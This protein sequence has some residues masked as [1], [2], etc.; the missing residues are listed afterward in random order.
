MKNVRLLSLMLVLMLVMS[1]VVTGFAAEATYTEAEILAGA[2]KD[3]GYDFTKMTADEISACVSANTRL[4]VG[5]DDGAKLSINH[6]SNFSGEIQLNGL[7]YSRTDTKAVKV[8]F[9]APDAGTTID[10]ALFSD[11]TRLRL[12][13]YNY[14]GNVVLSCSKNFFSNYVVV[15]GTTYSVIAKKVADDTISVYVKSDADTGYTEILSNR[16]VWINDTTNNWA[17]VSKLSV[18]GNDANDYAIFK[19]VYLYGD[20]YAEAD[21]LANTAKGGSL[22]FTQMT[23]SEI[24]AFGTGGTN[25]TTTKEN[26]MKLE[27]S[28]SSKGYAVVNLGL[29]YSSTANKAVKVT[30]VAPQSGTTIETDFRDAGERYRIYT[31]AAG[32]IGYGST[33]LSGSYV[34]T[35]GETYTVIGKKDSEGK[36]SLY[37]KSAS[38]INYKK[39]ISGV[40]PVTG[41]FSSLFQI[42]TVGAPGASTIFKEVT[43]YVEGGSRADILGT[44]TA[45][46]HDYDFDET[47]DGVKSY[48][49]TSADGFSFEKYGQSTAKFNSACYIPDGGAAVIRFKINNSK[50]EPYI[51]TANN[52][53]GVILI[54]ANGTVKLRTVSN[55]HSYDAGTIKQNTWYTMILK[56]NGTGFDFYMSESDT[57]NFALRQRTGE[58]QEATGT[59]SSLTGSAG[60]CVD[61]F[62]IYGPG[63]EIPSDEGMKLLHDADFAQN[64]DFLTCERVTATNASISNDALALKS[65]GTNEGSYKYADAGIP[66]GGY[67]EVSAK[68]MNF[69]A[70]FDQDDFN[71]SLICNAVG[72]D[73]LADAVVQVSPEA[74]GGGWQK[75][76]NVSHT[77]NVTYTYRIY[78]SLDNKFTI[79]RMAEGSSGWVKMFDNITV[80]TVDYDPACA[81]SGL[82]TTVDYVKIYAPV[83]EGVVMTDGDN[84]TLFVDGTTALKYPNELRV[85]ANSNQNGVMVLGLY[86]GD[87][88]GS[89][90]IENVVANT[91]KDVVKDVSS[92][93]K[94]RVFFWDSFTQMN[95]LY[96][97]SPEISV[98]AE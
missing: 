37:A 57:E 88:L 90:M 11:N 78:R 93:E 76:V 98:V 66:L 30:F 42:Y 36:M 81:L 51:Y 6:A 1:C 55:T 35:P 50:L 71:M 39:I 24:A 15:P 84:T 40:D 47:Y 13:T 25:A 61:Y 22:D 80:R 29:T 85:I 60:T 8:T 18:S 44:A 86:D 26:G 64:P 48:D 14:N 97:A 9:V 63:V 46:Y 75:A 82:D 45:V 52:T 21:L 12:F 83:S 73:A 91:E 10:V 38:D 87:G 96:E 49:A 31:N 23:E 2:A 94:V 28:S 70:T 69:Q 74:V 79:Y 67:A 17:D 7:P 16:S 95:R 68:G 54:A 62:T 53:R 59:Q 89:A 56:D 58:K 3:A 4:T 33:N 19:E 5:A 41:S 72:E 65:D 77:S 92:A 34:M 20:G 32:Q 27:V 43:Q